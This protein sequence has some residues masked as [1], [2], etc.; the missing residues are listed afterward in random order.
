MRSTMILVSLLSLM[1][2]RCS[3]PTAGDDTQTTSGILLTGTV[4]NKDGQPLPG[5]VARLKGL[6]LADTTDATGKYTISG[7]L[8]KRL[9]KASAAD[10]E[11]TLL[12]LRDGQLITWY[13]VVEWVDTL[14]ALFV[15]QRNI[16]GPLQVGTDSIGKVEAVLHGDG[17]SDSLPL[18]AEL[19]F[20][21]AVSEYSGF[22]YFAYST[23]RRDYAVYVNAYNIDTLW[24][25]R[26]D[27]IN[28]TSLAGDIEIP[29]FDAENAVWSPSAGRDTAVFVGGTILLGGM[30]EPTFEG[31]VTKWEWKIADSP[32]V[33]TSTSDTAF[34]APSTPIDQLVCILRVTDSFGYVKTD[35]I[36]V[37]VLETGTFIQS[38][39]ITTAE[40]W[41]KASSP[42]FLQG[43]VQVASGA[44]LTIEPG[45][46]V[47]YY[48]S[49]K[50]LVK[51]GAVVANGTAADSIRLSSFR[52][53]QGVTLLKF[54]G[55]DL[56]TSQLSYLA[57]GNAL[58]AV[59]VGDEAEHSQ[60]PV[61]NSGTLSVTHFR[62]K[63][64]SIVADGYQTSA[65]V[66]LSY[67]E[68]ESSLVHGTYPRSEPIG[69]SD[70]HIAYSTVKSDSYNK[71]VTLNSCTCSEVEFFIGCCG[72][73]IAITGST[74]S[75]STFD[76]CCGNPITGPLSI[77]SSAVNDVN[78]DL[79]N[80]Q[81]DASS[82]TFTQTD[83]TDKITFGNGS[84]SHCTF[85]GPNG[86]VG[87]EVTGY[88]GYNI[89]GT[90]AIDSCKISGFSAGILFT[91]AS[92]AT[93]NSCNLN[94]NAPY[95]IRNAC[96][97]SID[98]TNNYWGTTDESAIA[99]LIYDYADNI[100][101]GTV[102]FTPYESSEL[103]GVG[104]Q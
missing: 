89:G 71:G 26:S 39:T 91:G 95:A 27:T 76:G 59:R 75:R 62:L 73:N 35:T 100:E 45:T 85:T 99:G 43:D 98:A 79:P 19:W 86:G 97:K 24:I 23:E 49:C 14:P 101:F 11:D 103:T 13:D 55:V 51:G 32:F 69:I 82:S 36:L 22:I 61:K 92:T 65:S 2:L 83:S 47:F 25:G 68:I 93:A 10:V 3:L 88:S 30:A 21:Q 96:D 52:S 37:E 12:I 72:G 40:T 94:G 44:T 54:E 104:N 90:A 1:F 16:S 6:G 80:L 7:N 42:Y 53:S 66:S 77:V 41:T 38:K 28:F 60:A 87:L 63:G 20:N 74:V 50:I 9:A 56:S 29:A 67:A 58:E 17:I 31:T 46:S 8:Q 34:T 84:I 48:D 33:Q 64:S 78:I 102:S 4:S 5:A 70:A 15:V 81:F 18:I 57:F